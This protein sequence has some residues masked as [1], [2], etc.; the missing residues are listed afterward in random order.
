[1]RRVILAMLWLAACGDGSDREAPSASVAVASAHTPAPVARPALPA[2]E[3]VDDVDEDSDTDVD[4]AEDTAIDATDEVAD[5]ERDPG[6]HVEHV[7]VEI[8]HDSEDIVDEVDRCPDAPEDDDGF[9]DIDGCP[10]PDQGP[11]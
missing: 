8:D 4:D 7:I 10:E 9:E 5:A 1:M 2:I 3:P 6:V 11:R